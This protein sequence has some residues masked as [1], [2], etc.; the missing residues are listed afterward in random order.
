MVTS[1]C[2]EEVSL[3]VCPGITCFDKHKAVANL[4]PLILIQICNK[5]P[6]IK[7]TPILTHRTHLLPKV[8]SI[9]T[10]NSISRNCMWCTFLFIRFRCI[11]PWSNNLGTKLTWYLLPTTKT[12]SGAAEK[13]G[14]NQVSYL[15]KRVMDVI[16]QSVAHRKYKI[17]LGSHCGG[18]IP[19]DREVFLIMS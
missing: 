11:F 18:S 10:F 7:G 3:A 12:P 13:E 19:A 2:K 4:Y 15:E 5:Y 6:F 17:L 1:D 9:Q 14:A 16:K 8:S